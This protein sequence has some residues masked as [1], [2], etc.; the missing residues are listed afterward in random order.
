VRSEEE[1]SVAVGEWEW[2]E[3]AGCGDYDKLMRLVLVFNI[4][5]QIE[6]SEIL[7]SI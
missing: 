5:A 6:D 2:V 4:Q 3:R 1:Y 7:S